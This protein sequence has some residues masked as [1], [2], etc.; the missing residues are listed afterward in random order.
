M[1]AD[2]FHSERF[3]FH[4]CGF[5]SIHLPDYTNKNH[6]ES[7]ANLI[8]APVVS[9]KSATKVWKWRGKFVSLQTECQNESI[10][11]GMTRIINITLNVPETYQVEEL[12]RQLTEYGERLIARSKP[13][14]KPR[15]RPS[16]DFLK[17]FML[18]KGTTP[19]QLIDEHLQE[20]Y[21]N[22]I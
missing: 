14:A 6:H 17:S 8:R 7:H 10:F 9:R 11:A 4:L 21:Y 2:Y 16:Q 15:R 18:P 20:K 3:V 22:C 19:E 12:T 5:L 13:S 1:S